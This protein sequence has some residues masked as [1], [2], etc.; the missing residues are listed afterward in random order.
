MSFF[1]VLLIG[2]SATGK[3]SLAHRLVQNSFAETYRATL[4]CEFSLKIVEVAGV[5][6]RV[7][8]WDIAG[9]D[10]VAALNRIYCRDAAGALV[11]CDLTR[12]G[13]L[14]RVA[15]WRRSVEEQS[16]GLPMILCCNKLDLMRGA[17]TDL[18]TRCE[19]LSEQLGFK[20]CCFVS[21]KTGD[22]AG[23]ALSCLVA[24]IW[25]GK[26]RNSPPDETQSVKLSADGQVPR[27]CR[28]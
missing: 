7:Q 4:G 5:P 18:R 16:P 12:P 27:R 9:Q 15:D 3:T 19:T 23:E 1:K 20:H 10:R 17:W 24:E 6:L 8:L 2:D 26:E 11:V 14:E 25:S 21:A 28:C 13:S 22:G